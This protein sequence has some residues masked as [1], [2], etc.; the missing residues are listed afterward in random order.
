MRKNVKV[1]FVIAAVLLAANCNSHQELQ[2][3]ASDVA[4]AWLDINT[5]LAPPNMTETFFSDGII[6]QVEEFNDSLNRFIN[7]PVGY[8]YRTHRKE[9][10]R[11][12]EI[13][14]AVNR[15]KT[16]MQNGN[17]R[18][19]FQVSLKLTGRLAYCRKLTRNFRLQAC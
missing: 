6:L 19:F 8:L 3:S 17:E 10:M 7:S 5:K 9:D 13:S 2:P 14:A 1:F 18:K 16:A 11:L 4:N 15:L 12:L